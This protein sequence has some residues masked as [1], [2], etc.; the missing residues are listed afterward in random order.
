MLL[1]KANNLSYDYVHIDLKTNEQLTNPE[2]LAINP[3]KRIPAIEDSGYTLYESTAILKYIVN[4]YRL[5]EH[6][7]PKDLNKQGRVDE[8]LAWFPQ[9]LR[10]G[11]YFVTTVQPRKFGTVTPEA[12]LESTQTTLKKSVEVLE[13]YF[14]KN[15]KFVAGDEISIADL[16]FVSEVSQYLKMGYNLCEG[17]PMMTQWMDNVKTY[18]SPHYDE[19][20]KHEYQTIE[21]KTFFAEMKYF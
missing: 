16:L 12:I 21:A 9:N 20:Y 1:L 4:K 13:S 6:W 14:L 19:L 8:A 10:C 17:R 15:T 7:Y 11:A 5:P 2:L 3:N 18:L